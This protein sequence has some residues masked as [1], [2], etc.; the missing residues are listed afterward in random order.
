M[1]LSQLDA[2]APATTTTPLRRHAAEL[3]PLAI[4]LGAVALLALFTNAPGRYIGDNRFELYWA[5]FD[6]LKRHLA[7]WDSTRGLGRPRWDF[8]PATA[9][10]IAL[11]RGIGLGPDAAERVWQAALVTTAGTG[12]AA[13]LRQ[14]RPR[15]GPEHW[16][17]AFLYGFGPFAAVYLVPTNLF[18]GHAF[19]PWFLYAFVRGVRESRP[20]RWAAF[21]ALLVFVPGNMNYPALI[22]AALPIVPAAL[23]L[24]VVERSVEWRRVGAWLLRAGV[25]TLVVSAAALV[26]VQASSAINEENLKLTETVSEINRTSSWSE[27]WRGLG[28][29]GA[30]WGD[31]RGAI[32]P[33]FA[34]FFSWPVVLATFV[35]PAAA[36]STLWRS[37]WRAR[38]LFAGVLVLGLVLMVGAFPLDDPTPYGRALLWAYDHFPGILAIRSGHKAGVLVALG[39]ATL[40]AVAFA[41][42]IR[43]A[44]DRAG[45]WRRPLPVVIVAGVV[46]VVAAGAFPFWTGR[47]FSPDDG[48]TAVPAYWHEAV[49]VLDARPGHGR[50]LVLP[51]TAL[52]AYTWGRTGDDIVDGL[53]D[54]PAIARGLL[55]TWSGTEETANVVAALDDYVNSGRYER[56]VIGPIA[57]RLGIEYVLVRNDLDW[58]ATQ[59][60]R[61]SSFDALRT[62]PDLEL[63]GG[64]G[65][66]GENVARADAASAREATLPPLQLYRVRPYAGVARAD[67]RPPLVVSGDGD[68]WP[69]LAADGALRRGGP[70]RYSGDA[71]PR[72]LTRLLERG[73]AVVVS[74]SNRRRAHE[75]PIFDS[76]ARSS[77]TLAAGQELRRESTDLF[78]TPGSQTVAHFPDA[79]R[80]EASSY[81]R[82]ALPQASLRPANAFDG[83]P[84]TS[85]RIAPV[86]VD[87]HDQWVRAV[88]DHP[89][90]LDRVTVEATPAQPSPGAPD[91]MHVTRVVAVLSDGSRHPID[92]ADGHGSITLPGADTTSLE[93]RI[94]GI[95]GTDP[96]PFGLSEVTVDSHGRRLDLREEI[97]L[98]DDLARRAARSPKLRRALATAP[99][100]YQLARAE[101]LD[102]REVETTLR[103]RLRTTGT[104]AYEVR[105]RLDDPSQLA[106]TDCQDIGLRIDGAA[107]PVRAADDGFAGCAPVELIE[108]WHRVDTRPR[109][110]IRRVWLSAGE[111]PPAASAGRDAATLTGLG[112]ADFD[113]DATTA[114]PAAIV[115]G[116]SGDDGWSATIDGRDAGAPVTLDTQASWHVSRAGTHRLDAH[117]D[118]QGPYRVAL[119]VTGIGLLLCIVLLVRGRFR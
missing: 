21:F 9:A 14:L 65:A 36:I 60:P 34:R 85:W 118:A 45:T 80:V 31:S 37:R 87:E 7:V 101:P 92:L 59:R 96:Q 61:P 109:P 106:G 42:A 4:A 93:L 113:I 82:P 83:D 54:R 24:C 75:I 86:F 53:L 20:W 47:L 17:V 29:W 115:S 51:S 69:G 116:Q 102:G 27:S 56:G 52:G 28:F 19:A 35:V 32:V 81:G 13:V 108:G 91:P 15:V 23:Y 25:L 8:W 94:E 100:T 16:L 72:E 119:A 46:V 97:Q 111:I 5:P 1:A 66:P 30:Y 18:I 62:D 89:R 49:D 79:A 55:S 103:R 22:F 76:I 73:S 77:Y 114:G 99:V 95:A 84:S 105:G 44:R 10:A 70:L 90:R 43:M 12:A 2:A 3:W 67:G 68:A 112:R 57:R 39:A 64:F 33:Q 63:L 41:A 98:P 110:S 11:L 6:L 48:I 74:D 117:Q 38:L 107:V 88:F 50:V 71:S 104:R 26:T 40:A 58:P 78:E